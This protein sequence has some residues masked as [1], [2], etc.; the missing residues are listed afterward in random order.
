MPTN[1]TK[2]RQGSPADIEGLLKSALRASVA[3]ATWLTD[4]DGVTIEWAF[5]LA[6]KLDRTTELADIARLGKLFETCTRDLGL[7]IAGRAAKPDEPVR[8]ESPLDEIRKAVAD[9]KS[10]AKTANPKRTSA[11]PVK[12]VGSTRTSSRTPAASVASKPRKPSTQ[13]KK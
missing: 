11:K 2:T 7:S 10:Q 4:A 8:E 9:R 3:A 1:T 5:F 12:R 6:D 13:G